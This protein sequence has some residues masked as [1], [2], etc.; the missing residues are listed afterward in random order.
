[1]KSTVARSKHTR[2]GIFVGNWR[3]FHYW[4]G[5]HWSLWNIEVYT[6]EFL[7]LGIADNERGVV[8]DNVGE[9]RIDA[10]KGS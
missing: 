4:S 2:F 5:E 8:L 7:L 10:R 3:P 6:P 9:P 1:M